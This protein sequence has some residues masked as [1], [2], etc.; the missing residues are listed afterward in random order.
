M[1][2]VIGAYL[3]TE[4]GERI[5]I[6]GES[7]VGR[8]EEATITFALSSVSRKHA[9]IRPRSGA[10]WLLDLGSKNGTFVNGQS[11]G[12]EAVCLGHGDEIVFG[13]VV[14]VLFYDPAATPLAPRIG[15]L[16]GVWIDPESSAVWVDAVRIEPPLSPKQL[17]LL[18]LLDANAGDI[19][20]RPTIVAKIWADAAA[21]GVSDDA[22]A[23]L[24]K[25]LRARLREGPRRLDYV[26][27]VKGRGIRIPA[28]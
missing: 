13:G 6:A 25:R 20:S 16:D 8:S 3:A 19:V 24:V 26:E 14:K 22:V 27:V 1:M 5:P 2:T 18:Q 9:R 12:S 7:S 28:H 21:E 23:A 17:Q 10:W 4:A 15:R 11:V